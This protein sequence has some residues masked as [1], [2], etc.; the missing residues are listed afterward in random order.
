ML[1]TGSVPMIGNFVRES[2][3]LHLF[4]A[5]IMREH[6]IFLQAS[7]YPKDVTYAQQAEQFKCQYDEILKEALMLSDCTASVEVLKSGELVTNETLRSEQKTQELTGILIDMTLTT[8][9]FRVTQDQ[10]T[11][12]AE[13]Q[14]QVS[15][16]NHKSINLTTSFAKFKA[17]VLNQVT[18]C[19]LATNLF[20]SQLE[21]VYREA[22][23]YLKVIKRMQN[24]QFVDG[25]VD[26]FEQE[27]F[28]GE[29]MEEH[30]MFVRH[31]LD[32]SEKELCRKA[33]DLARRFEQLEQKM[34]GEG[35]PASSFGRL[36]QE[37]IAA[38]LSIAEFKATGTELLL[39]CQV[40]SLLSPLLTDHTLREA[41]YYLRILQSWKPGYI[42]RG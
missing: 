15:E 21:H 27:V 29:I 9:E 42:G 40:K 14:P 41:N 36:R 23:F 16:L 32:P 8:E 26:L 12:P 28:W 4:F 25:R 1:A 10:G 24:N 30:A 13:I 3:D 35:L 22:L 7:F 18:H 2:L 20:P 19:H 34:K 11:I 39:A 38:T 6:A 33:R 5:R 31:L 17:M 37:N